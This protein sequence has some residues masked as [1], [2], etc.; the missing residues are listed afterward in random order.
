[1][2]E[3]ASDLLGELSDRLTAE[4]GDSPALTADV[5]R[6][7]VPEVVQAQPEGFSEMP[8]RSSSDFLTALFR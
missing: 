7:K 3:R 2:T 1:M 6:A 5:V 8:I 4:L